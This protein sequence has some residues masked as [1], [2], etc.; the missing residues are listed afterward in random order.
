MKTIFGAMGAACALLCGTAA[1]VRADE[2][3]LPDA[4]QVLLLD[5]ERLVEGDIHREGDRYRVRREL[6]ESWIPA[7]KVI[8][9]CASRAEAFQMLRSRANLRDLDE[10]LR[11]ARWCQLHGLMEQGLA[12]IQ[13]ALQIRPNCAE[14]RRLLRCFQRDAEPDTPQ[15]RAAVPAPP[16]PVKE[17]VATPAPN[18]GLTMEAA[19]LFSTRVQPILMNTCANC[20]ATEHGGAFRLIHTHGESSLNQRAT[21]VNLAAAVAQVNRANIAASPLLSK[22]ISIHGDLSQPPLKGRQMPAFATLEDWVQMVVACGPETPVAS[23]VPTRPAE[24]PAHAAHEAE[25]P[26]ASLWATDA[27][28]AVSAPAGT[29]KPTTPDTVAVKPGE[30]VVRDVARSVSTTP[31][32]TPV[33]EPTDEFDPIHFN[34]EAHPERMNQPKP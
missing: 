30:A 10:R 32:P 33:H 3:T 34:R 9:L 24:N 14:A 15:P 22:A 25:E 17:L 21:Q 7:D 26:K 4:G 6:G 19:T 18:A 16:A 20:H 11:L 5:N 1:L 23:A 31:P 12:E 27:R 13:G 8:R 2:P 28:P 29:P